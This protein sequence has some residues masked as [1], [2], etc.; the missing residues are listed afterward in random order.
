MG[1][2]AAKISMDCRGIS[3]EAV[4]DFEK[5]LRLAD[6]ANLES[7]QDFAQIGLFED[8]RKSENNG[9]TIVAENLKP[10]VRRELRAGQRKGFI[11]NIGSRSGLEQ[12]VWCLSRCTPLSFSSPDGCP[13]SELVREIELPQ[14][15]VLSRLNVIHGGVG[16]AIHRPLYLTETGSAALHPDM[17][18]RVSIK[19]GGLKAVGFLAGF[20]SIIFPAEYRGISIRVRGVAI[21]DP[22]F[23]GAEA[24]LTG[25]HKAALSQITGEIVVLGGLDAVD[26]LNPGRESFYEESEHFKILRRYMVGEGE[27]VGGQLG[28]IIS[29]VLRRSQVRSGITDVLGRACFRRRAL[30]DISAAV[31]HLISRGD[32]TASLLLS[33]LR[34]RRSQVNGL[35]FAR[36]HELTFPPRVGGLIVE[37]T[38]GAAEPAEIDYGKERI[39]LDTSRPEWSWSL[40]LFDRQ[41]E[42]LH[43]RG[44]VDQPIAEM[45]LGKGRIFINWGHPVRMQMEEKGFLRTAL[46]WVLAKEA[47]RKDPELMM[48]LAL[49]LMSF[50][51][52]SND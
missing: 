51:T 36:S 9:T 49:R 4:L 29:A 31:T 28:R 14:K 50:T 46:A 48:E 1:P 47:A 35:S 10:F 5:L 8:S 38:R 32:P 3:F 12:F 22:S 45:D 11:R 2:I 13:H 27:R 40:L 16:K 26:T 7:V 34:S 18:A 33:L 20:E 44:R 25:A 24:L 43:K 39:R 19:E 42:V 37:E 6:S 15:M 52:S 17:L 41:F 23:L 30:E 21:G